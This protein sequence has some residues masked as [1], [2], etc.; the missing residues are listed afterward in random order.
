MLIDFRNMVAKVSMTLKI[1]VENKMFVNSSLSSLNLGKQIQLIQG[2]DTSD[3]SL[4]CLVAT[5][6][7]NLVSFYFILM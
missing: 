6:I 1:K 3:D 5:S 4:Q 2:I 7:R